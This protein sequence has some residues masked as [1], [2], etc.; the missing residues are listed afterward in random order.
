MASRA[1]DFLMKGLPIDVRQKIYSKFNEDI[2]PMM[3]KG[4]LEKESG[5]RIFRASGYTDSQ[6]AQIEE[7]YSHKF[8]DLNEIMVE[9]DREPLFSNPPDSY[10]SAQEYVEIFKQRTKEELVEMFGADYASYQ[11][12]VLK[13]AIEKEPEK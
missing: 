2:S 10:Q 4:F 3:M 8:E 7:M 9:N 12:K 1:L 13:K 11:P 5:Y 6:I